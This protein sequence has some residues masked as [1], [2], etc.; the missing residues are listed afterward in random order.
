MCIYLLDKAMPH[1]DDNGSPP[2]RVINYLTQILKPGMEN[3]LQAVGQ[4][5]RKESKLV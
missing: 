2:P 1:W 4:G 5:H 3:T